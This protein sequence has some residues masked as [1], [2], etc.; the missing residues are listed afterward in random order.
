MQVSRLAAETFVLLSLAAATHY[1]HSF[2][3]S[4]GLSHPFQ[5]PG[6]PKCVFQLSQPLITTLRCR[7]AGT[8]MLIIEHT[9]LP[10]EAAPGYFNIL[11][12]PYALNRGVCTFTSLDRCSLYYGSFKVYQCLLIRLLVECP[13]RGIFI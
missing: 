11:R 4:L 5:S 12:S 13:L 2:A 1:S 7:S 6:E 9:S 8:A 3:T 10:I